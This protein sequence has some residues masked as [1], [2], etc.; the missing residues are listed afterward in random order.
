MALNNFYFVVGFP[1]A[2]SLCS[3]SEE[4][5]EGCFKENRKNVNF[6]FPR[7]MYLTNNIIKE[8]SNKFAFDFVKSP[9]R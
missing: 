9:S 8:V 1:T 2:F 3:F 5:R 4:V 7:K 6:S